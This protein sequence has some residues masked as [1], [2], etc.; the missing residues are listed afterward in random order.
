[1]DTHADVIVVGAGIVGL[2][3]ALA[4]AEQG[5]SVIVVERD[6]RAVGASIRNFGS[7]WPIG[8]FHADDTSDYDRGC[9]G[10]EVW[11]RIARETGMWC[12]DTGSLTV[13]CHRDE[14]DVLEE[15]LARTPAAVERGARLVGP[16]EVARLSPA[17]RPEAVLGAMHS[18]TEVNVDPVVAIPTVARW[19]QERHGVRFVRG[20]QVQRIVHPR[21]HTTAGALT[22]ERVF[23]CSGADFHTLYPELLGADVVRRCKLQML[24][25]EPQPD[26]WALGP[27]LCAGLTLLHYRSFAHLE[28]LPALRARLDAELPFHREHG[29]H[30]LVTQTARGGVTI[31]DS[32]EYARTVDPF[33]SR[34]VFDAVLDYLDG[35]VTL[36]HRRIEEYWH[37]VYPSLVGGRPHLVAE[38][39]PGVRL[40]NGLGGAGMTL[41]F[42]LAQDHL[43]GRIT[44]ER[45]LQPA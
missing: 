38:P 16:A 41:S 5:A 44:P 13:A 26:G 34:A 22:A 27:T 7:I 39:E 35:F 2:A 1:M 19:L 42:G 4:A 20:A 25:T 33:E 32:H 43:A 24:R 45:T 17:V 10:A 28:S 6:D 36:P 12:A 31:G 23:V 3:H 9:R 30:V 8:Q 11:R 18:P 40:V 21:V 37:G 15:F 14:L 29:I